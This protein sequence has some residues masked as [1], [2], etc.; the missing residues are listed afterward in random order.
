MNESSPQTAAEVISA[1]LR[2]ELWSETGPVVG[3]LLRLLWLA[4]SEEPDQPQ[5]HDAEAVS[6]SD[7]S[8]AFGELIPGRYTLVVQAQGF[9]EQCFE[10]ELYGGSLDRRCIV[11]DRGRVLRGRVQDPEGRPLEGIELVARQT[12]E[13][14]LHTRSAR[15][16]A[17]GSFELRGLQE[18]CLRLHGHDPRGQ[19]TMVPGDLLREVGLDEDAPVLTL[20]PCGSV[21]GWLRSIA[22]A[23]PIIGA[24]VTLD[25]PEARFVTRTDGDGCFEFLQVPAGDYELRAGASG[26]VPSSLQSVAVQPAQETQVGLL[27]ALGACQRGRVLD[28][29]GAPVR[30]VLV[31]LSEPGDDQVVLLERVVRAAL[32]RTGRA[33]SSDALAGLLQA[34]SAVDGSFAL[35]GLT[36][37]LNRL[38]VVAQ[39]YTMRVVQVVVRFDNEPPPLDIDLRPEVC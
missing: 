25:G 33:P 26:F 6:D 20:H 38:M 36:R 14:G 35:D 8:F 5:P 32:R 37:G 27:M 28:A 19:F 13:G 31:R 15:S 22:D 1:C 12:S 30:A 7:G 21:L 11:L 3:A 39:G 23:Q 29:G 34:T 10:V 16:A 2:G 4:G 17:D 9:Q 18:R 24:S